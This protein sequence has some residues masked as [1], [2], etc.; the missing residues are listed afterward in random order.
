M[1]KSNHEYIKNQITETEL[2]EDADCISHS[3]ESDEHYEKKK[4]VA[5]NHIYENWNVGVE[6]RFFGYIVDVIA[7]K[8]DQLKIIEVG[9]CK[10]EKLN[11]LKSHKDVTSV[12]NP[13]YKSGNC[14]DIMIKNVPE[15][16]YWKWKREKDT[17]GAPN[18]REFFLHYYKEDDVEGINQNES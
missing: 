8:Q 6:E 16:Q 15:D 12:K 7:V 1:N 11:D 4:Q 13:S 14:K 10:D 5:A 2:S 9:D 3:V 18:W 17:V